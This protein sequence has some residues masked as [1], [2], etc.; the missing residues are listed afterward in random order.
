[1]K[2]AI[3]PLAEHDAIV[4]PTVS[5][6]GITLKS[7]SVMQITNTAPITLHVRS[8]SFAGADLKLV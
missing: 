7:V 4:I 1:M 6:K 8:S 3:R 2:Q 5:Q